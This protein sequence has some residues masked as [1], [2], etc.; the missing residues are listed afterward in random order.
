M[1]RE[2]LTTLIAKLTGRTKQPTTPTPGKDYAGDRETDRLGHL[3]EEDRAW[4]ADRSQRS[5]DAA[6]RAAGDRQ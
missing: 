5:R 1:L 6:A 4:E 2:R 3:S